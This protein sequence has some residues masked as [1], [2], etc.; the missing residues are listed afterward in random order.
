VD[1]L[2][3]FDFEARII[4][5]QEVDITTLC[6]LNNTSLRH[7]AQTGLDRRMKPVPGLHDAGGLLDQLASKP[8]TIEHDDAGA[9]LEHEDDS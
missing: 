4:N 3:E 8:L 1:V 7:S 5:G 2:L 6:T 9:V